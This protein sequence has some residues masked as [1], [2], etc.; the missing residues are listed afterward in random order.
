MSSLK[1]WL[2]RL[3]KQ[4]LSGSGI[5]MI[6]CF[7]REIHTFV[8]VCVQEVDNWSFFSCLVC[9]TLYS[10]IRAAFSPF[11]QLINDHCSIPLVN[12]IYVVKSYFDWHFVFSL[13][14][15]NTFKKGNNV[16]TSNIIC[17]CKIR[18]CKH[19]NI[20]LNLPLE[21]PNE[22]KHSPLTMYIIPLDNRFMAEI[23]YINS[24]ILDCILV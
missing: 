22:M 8:Q 24:W 23:I 19:Q 5:S 17:Q 7:L 3:L 13:C 6:S 9:A 1:A 4:I 12:D 10:L 14:F 20:G 18:D 11:H 21:F 2:K 15:N 16:S